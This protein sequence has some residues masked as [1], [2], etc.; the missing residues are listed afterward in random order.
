MVY[1]M[2]ESEERDGFY[3]ICKVLNEDEIMNFGDLLHILHV[4]IE[5][6]R[7]LFSPHGCHTRI[8]TLSHKHD[9]KSQSDQDT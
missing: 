2:T 5:S 9:E 1:L 4:L 3:G 8:P 7:F 6:G